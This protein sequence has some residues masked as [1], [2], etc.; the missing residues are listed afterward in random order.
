MQHAI[1]NGDLILFA[2]DSNAFVTGSTIAEV[3]HNANYLCT[4]LNNWF[5]C[6]LLSVNYDKSCY[7]LFYPAQEDEDII[8]SKKLNLVMA[9]KILLRVENVKFLGVY[10]DAQLN[11]KKH[12]QSV[13]SKINS[14]RGMLYNRR[15]FLPDPCRKMLYFAL[16]QSRI[17]Y[18]IEVYGFT[19]NHII[20]PLQ[21]AQNRTLR[22]LQNVDRYFSVKELYANYNTLPVHLLSKFNLCKLVYTSLNVQSPS[23]NSVYDL[24]KLNKPDHNYPTRLSAT[25]YLFKKSNKAFFS[26]YVNTACSA[27][28]EI[29]VN[30]RNCVT[31]NIFAKMYKQHLFTTWI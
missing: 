25:N 17:Q 15:K 3:Y 30:I 4:E 10:F 6:N 11:F 16:I 20:E 8:A 23:I 28:N 24:F 31:I 26:S 29:P 7:M 21:I 1:S 5:T 2:D 22:C 27:W 14:L 12:V 18:G 19:N 9:N 13:I